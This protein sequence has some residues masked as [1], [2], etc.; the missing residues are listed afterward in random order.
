MRRNN[1]IICDR[2]LINLRL[3]ELGRQSA[4]QKEEI[5]RLLNLL[6]WSLESGE[7]IESNLK[8]CVSM[9][10]NY[11]KSCLKDIKMAKEAIKRS[12]PEKESWEPAHK[13]L[14][15][16]RKEL[17]LISKLESQVNEIKNLAEISLREKKRQKTKKALF[18][19]SVS[20]FIILLILA[21][22]L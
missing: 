6:K 5:D 12:S 13:L 15:L 19:G 9:L 22:S 2:V 8:Q 18:L 16:R 21:M 7:Y 1:Q 3:D 14:D 4:R 20:L 11:K 17:K 10:E